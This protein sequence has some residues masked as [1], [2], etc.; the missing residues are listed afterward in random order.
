MVAATARAFNMK[1]DCDCI[2][3]ALHKGPLQR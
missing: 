2:G 3:S 1:T